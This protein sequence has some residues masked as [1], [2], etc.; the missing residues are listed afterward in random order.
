MTPQLI[1]N[2]QGFRPCSSLSP[3]YRDQ[4]SAGRSHVTS[5]C[6]STFSKRERLSS[7][8]SIELDMIIINHCINCILTYIIVSPCF[9]MFPSSPPLYIMHMH[10][11]AIPLFPGHRQPAS[12][13][14]SA[15]AS[16]HCPVGHAANS[17]GPRRFPWHERFR[18]GSPA[19]LYLLVQPGKHRGGL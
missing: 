1:I 10:S 5:A 9:P 17:A 11:S 13:T 7:P 4:I 3:K 2:H 18:P 14:T 12:P 8:W 15:A 16:C 19:E 6:G